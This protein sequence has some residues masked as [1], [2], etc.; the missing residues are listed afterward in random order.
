MNT[1]ATNPGTTDV[2]LQRLTALHPKV[3]DLSLGRMVG[4]LHKLGNPHTQVPPVIHVAG[5]NGKG[6][7]IAFMRAIL[8]AAGLSVHVYTSPHLVRFHERI[9]LAAPGGG[10][11]IAEDALADL[12]EECERI[13][14]ADPITFF[15]ITTAAAFLAFAR[16]PADVLLLETGLGGRLD[17]TNVID[18]PAVTVITPV[19]H[20]HH[21]YLGGDLGG[22]AAEKAGILKAGVPCVVSAQ[23][24]VA[25]TT[26]T[27]I[28]QSVGAPLLRFGEA[29][30]IVSTDTGLCWTS[31]DRTIDA[32]APALP[33]P[34]QIHN[35]G[36]AITALSRF[37]GFDLDPDAVATGMQTVSWPARMQRLTRGP[38][39]EQLP[40]GS[41][42]WL[43]GGHNGGAGAALAAI[44]GGSG[45]GH[46]L[47]MPLH[48]I[49]GMLNSKEPDDFLRPLAPFVTR[50]QC[51]TIPGEANSFPADHIHRAARRIGIAA[52]CAQSIDEAVASI[53]DEA[54]GKPVQVLICGSLYLAGRI[55]ADHS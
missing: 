16:H 31:E 8:E 14:G 35:A 30:T 33:G 34:H 6:S 42:L 54:D 3:I 50:A 48:L 9:R 10:Q 25:Q 19:S 18:T 41:D 32:P 28:A 7:V 44:L 5:T 4:L 1:P 27:R 12:L 52:A 45:P 39:L 23:P 17:A 36:C 38:I 40:D 53:V 11:L 13:N 46:H 43:D 15:E 55:L 21:Q 37:S 29:W 2:L 47:D 22:I 49:V 51:V 26:I 20:D 24:S